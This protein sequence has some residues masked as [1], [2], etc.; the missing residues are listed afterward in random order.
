MNLRDRVRLSPQ[1]AEAFWWLIVAWLLLDALP[2]K[3]YLRILPPK[4]PAM[5]P[6]PPQGA[7]LDP[8]VRT[9]SHVVDYVS[10][11]LP[12]RSVC[13]H[14]AIA[15]DRMLSRRRLPRIMHYG[16]QRENNELK[17]HVWIT[18]SGFGVIGTAESREYTEIAQFVDPTI[19]PRSVSPQPVGIHQ[20]LEHR[21]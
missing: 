12:V 1:A 4:R 16:V 8:R 19:V 9:I 13:F 14:R 21:Q 15:V 6:Q 17:A 20:Q 18:S 11:F 2:G 5:P 10:R 7:A 3:L